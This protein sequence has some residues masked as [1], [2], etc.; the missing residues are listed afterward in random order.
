MKIDSLLPVSGGYQ[1]IVPNIAVSGTQQSS[2]QH[3]EDIDGRETNLDLYWFSTS[4]GA[5]IKIP[6]VNIVPEGGFIYDMLGN[7]VLEGIIRLF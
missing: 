7:N 4:P 3:S 1:I 6:V 5:V 2:I